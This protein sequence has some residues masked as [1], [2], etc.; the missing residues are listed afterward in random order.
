M[1]F[2]DPAVLAT[3]TFR[4]PATAWYPAVF[5][6][7]S[8]AWLHSLTDLSSDAQAAIALVILPFYTIPFTATGWIIGLIVERIHRHRD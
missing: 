2:P 8:S 6:L 5:A 4:K 1:V 3:F 7:A